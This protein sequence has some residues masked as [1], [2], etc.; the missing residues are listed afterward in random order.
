MRD[1]EVVGDRFAD[2]AHLQEAGLRGGEHFREAAETGEQRLGQRLGVGAPDDLEEDQ[3]E[4]L[5]VGEGVGAGV[6]KT[7]LQAVAM[8]DIVGNLAARRRRFL[9][10][11]K[12]GAAGSALAA[13]G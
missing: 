9:H 7:L 4:E 1:L 5:V 2:A 10:L 13:T 11:V 12:P 6:A 8:A 3:L